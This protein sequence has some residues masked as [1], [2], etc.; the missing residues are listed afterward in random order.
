MPYISRARRE[1]F[2]L[3]RNTLK[4]TRL[5]SVGELVYM[6]CW[7]ADHYMSQ[8]IM[9]FENLNAVIGAF[10]SAKAEFYRKMIAEYEEGKEST[11]G[12]VWKQWKEDK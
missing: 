7:M 2:T 3:A 8:H 5:D 9:N 12:T 4:S 10:E 11:H 6:F 1:A